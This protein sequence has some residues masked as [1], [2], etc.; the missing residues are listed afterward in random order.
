[1]TP[2]DLESTQTF[3]HV[4]VYCHL[5]L[6]FD[7]LMRTL[8]GY[9]LF[10]AD[11]VEVTFNGEAKPTVKIRPPKKRKFRVIDEEVGGIVILAGWGHLRLP[12]STDETG[13]GRHPWGDNAWNVEFDNFLADYLAVS[14]AEILLDLRRRTKKQ[15]TPALVA[16][17]TEIPTAQPRILTEEEIVAIEG[18]PF[19]GMHRRRERN[20]A[21]V[22]AKK[23][24]VLE[25]TGKLEC[26]V[27]GF[28][29]V[30][31]YGIEFCEVHHLC[32]LGDTESAVVTRLEDLA[33]VCSNC[34]RAV[35][36]GSPF[37]TISQLRQRIEER[38][39]VSREGDIRD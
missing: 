2:S 16:P 20:P 12:G 24:Q 22:A 11:R 13:M 28:D 1:M 14:K 36:R 15:P 5:T 6:P 18:E 33:V 9:S 37:F 29:F 3:E 38:R 34:H 4:S 39:K 27:C 32:P 7:G 8:L 19:V 21:I 26:E 17:P 10:E 30:A 23:R 35:H 25:R 31:V